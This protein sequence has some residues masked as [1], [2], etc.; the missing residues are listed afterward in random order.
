MYTYIYEIFSKHWLTNTSIVDQTVNMP[1]LCDSHLNQILEQN[2]KSI[3]L[4]NKPI[5]QH[6]KINA[7]SSR[8]CACLQKVWALHCLVHVKMHMLHTCQKWRLGATQ[9]KSDSTN[10]TIFAEVLRSRLIHVESRHIR[11]D[12]YR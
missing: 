2:Q 3:C 1:I 10:M 7:S 12:W 9:I 5:C 4:K 11:A 6:G 8:G